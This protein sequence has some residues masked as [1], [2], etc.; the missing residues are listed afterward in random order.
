MISIYGLHW[1]KYI[2]NNG[3]LHALSLYVLTFDLH[4]RKIAQKMNDFFVVFGKMMKRCG[5]ASIKLQIISHSKNL[6]KICSSRISHEMLA[7][8][9]SPPSFLLISTLIFAFTFVYP[10]DKCV[11]CSHMHTLCNGYKSGCFIHIKQRIHTRMGV[12]W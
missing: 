2:R 4:R 11:V 3:C 10:V 12:S 9:F 7:I 6:F 1:N 8:P 5:V